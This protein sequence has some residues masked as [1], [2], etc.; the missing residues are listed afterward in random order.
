MC[1]QEKLRHIWCDIDVLQQPKKCAMSILQPDLCQKSMNRVLTGGV[2]CER[3][4]LVNGL[5]NGC[6]MAYKK[7]GLKV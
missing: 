6:I 2:A 1:T 5:D 7:D 3:C 4:D